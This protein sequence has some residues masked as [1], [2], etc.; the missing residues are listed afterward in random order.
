[1]TT[2]GKVPKNHLLK[3]VTAGVLVFTGTIDQTNEIL[4][5]DVSL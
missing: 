1:M 3:I 2:G 5:G 4:S